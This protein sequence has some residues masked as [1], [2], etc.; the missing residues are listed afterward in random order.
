MGCF[1]A[2]CFLL[3]FL[4]HVQRSPPVPLLSSLFFF[5]LIQHVGACGVERQW[6]L[7]SLAKRCHRNV[8]SEAVKE[9]LFHAEWECAWREER[10]G[11][12]CWCSL[13]LSPSSSST[14][15]SSS[16]SSTPLPLHVHKHTLALTHRHARSPKV[17]SHLLPLPCAIG[18]SLR[19]TQRQGVEAGGEW[20]DRGGGER[21]RGGGCGRWRE[22]GRKK[23]EVYSWL[24]VVLPTWGW[25][26]S[27][28]KRQRQKNKKWERGGRGR[29]A[30]REWEKAEKKTGWWD[31]QRMRKVWNGVT[32]KRETECKGWSRRRGAWSTRSPHSAG[33]VI[34]AVAP[35]T[36]VVIW[37]ETLHSS[38]RPVERQRDREREREGGSLTRCIRSFQKRK[39][40]H[41][42]LPA[43]S[44]YWKL[45]QNRTAPATDW[46]TGF[47]VL[48]CVCV[49]VCV[50]ETH[51]CRKRK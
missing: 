50:I 1:P 15:S 29:E 48:R 45:E 13:S 14:S 30:E 16:S 6:L 43:G 42:P 28:R 49:C 5:V 9:G 20:G 31:R 19:R 17:H 37:N 7:S 34:S 2:A 27:K 35:C 32:G 40:P 41:E 39:S 8:H 22:E 36:D 10:L 46:L 4:T 11:G 38:D 21:W 24:D 47:I 51:R 3:S 44:A 18:D 12:L 33:W 26:R 23:K 25:R